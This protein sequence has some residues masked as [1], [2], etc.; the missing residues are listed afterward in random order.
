MQ[1]EKEILKPPELAEREKRYHFNAVGGVIAPLTWMAVH[2]IVFYLFQIPVISHLGVAVCLVMG[3]A[4]YL[5]HCRKYIIASSINTLMHLVFIGTGM[6]I[7]GWNSGMQFHLIAMGVM[8]QIHI[9]GHGTYKLMLG[10]IMYL[11]ILASAIYAAYEVPMFPLSSPYINYLLFFN[12]AFSMLIFFFL[13]THGNILEQTEENL[14]Q[15][16]L[17]NEQLLHNVLPKDVAR[18]LRETSSVKPAK[19]EDVTIMF[20]DFIG[21]TNIVA[22]IPA[23]KLIEELNDIFSEFDDIVES[24]GIEKIKTIGDAYLAAS[25]LPASVPDHA[26]RCVHA[27]KKMIGYLDKRN[28]TAAIKWKIRIGLH[29]GPISAGVIGKR[30]FAYDI[31]GDTINTASRIESN[32]E[33]NRINVSA[34]TYDLIKEVFTCEYRG[35]LNAKGKGE[36]DM[37]FVK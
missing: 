14:F 33:E 32:G 13:N 1:S 24:E 9:K 19:F 27:A 18:E 11:A 15:A 36:L 3:G 20:T 7:V 31:F 17:K 28:E 26:I 25:G 34:Y 8:V 21:F 16:G 5:A 12:I 23:K 35:K 10:T 2:T 37:Y 4:V 6:A 22:T 30:K 29:S